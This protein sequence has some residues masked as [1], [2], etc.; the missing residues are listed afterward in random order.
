MNV[1]MINE[2]K[3]ESPK[4]LFD[5]GPR[6]I[7]E[8]SR[9]ARLCDR[10]PLIYHFFPEGPALLGGLGTQR[11]HSE[12]TEIHRAVTRV[13]S[14]CFISFLAFCRFLYL[15]NLR[16]LC[17]FGKQTLDSGMGIFSK[18]VEKTYV[19]GKTIGK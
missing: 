19:L 13:K 18:G 9:S 1:M 4:P 17:L 14:F 11:S 15:L 12:L 7:T 16:I 10:G 8:T 3:K 6:G 2:G 5:H